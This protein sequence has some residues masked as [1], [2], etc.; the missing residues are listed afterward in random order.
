V[1][2]LHP[3][4]GPASPT[5]TRSSRRAGQETAAEGRPLS[6]AGA[7]SASTP[8]RRVRTP[9]MVGRELPRRRALIRARAPISIYEVHAPSGGGTRTRAVL[10][11]DELSRR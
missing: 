3:G 6:A 11:W 5:N 1:G 2:D 9:S 8:P 7:S 4:F 10:L